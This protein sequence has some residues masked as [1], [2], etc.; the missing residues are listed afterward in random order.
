[1]TNWI[2]VGPAEEFEEGAKVCTRAGSVE[3]VVFRV[4]DR[5]H[6]IRNEC[7]HAGLP[8]GEGERRGLIITCPFHGYAYNIKDGRNIDWPHDE[9]P[10][11][12]YPV[13]VEN[14]RL[15]IEVN[16][17]PKPHHERGPAPADKPA[18]EELP[19]DPDE[20]RSDSDEQSCPTGYPQQGQAPP[21][22]PTPEEPRPRAKPTEQGD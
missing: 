8:I 18:G 15:Q 2:D 16:A 5:F 17:V 11:K 4:N 3:V 19:C 21:N 22:Q 6:V 7:P 12:T 14:G 9:P 13:R 10:V 1:M 20:S